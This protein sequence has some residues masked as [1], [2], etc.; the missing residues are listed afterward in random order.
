M[1]TFPSARRWTAYE[2]AHCTAVFRFVPRNENFSKRP[3]CATSV[4]PSHLGRMA[5]WAVRIG[6]LA[7]G[8]GRW[9]HRTDARDRLSVPT[10]IARLARAGREAVFPPLG[11]TDYIYAPDLAAALIAL[12]D[13]RAP[14]HRLY[15]LGTGAAWSLPEWCELLA[16]R[17]PEF[18]WR[19]ARD[20]ECNVLPLSPATARASP[21]GAWSMTSAGRR[22]STSPWLPKILSAGSRPT[23]IS[24]R[25][26][27]RA[28][29]P[30]EGAR[31]SNPQFSRRKDP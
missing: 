30:E 17:F 11:P 27:D 10:E 1:L 26:Y 12:L 2:K 19:E 25:A 13:A 7:M 21:T 14:S 31:P 24:S 6:R 20:V 3:D 15:H 22:A 28:V 4:T 29:F 18:R 23:R 16:A 8:F 5:A 9:E